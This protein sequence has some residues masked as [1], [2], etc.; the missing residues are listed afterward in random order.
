LRVEEISP[1]AAR[2]E[3][4]TIMPASVVKMLLDAWSAAIG[5]PAFVGHRNAS[6]DVPRLG[7][8]S[9]CGFQL[10]I[11][12]IEEPTGF[13]FELRAVVQTKYGLL[14]TNSARVT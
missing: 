8:G 2:N 12:L 14:V 7:R 10:A 11:D 9:R 5:Q 6:A 13:L 3:L 4:L 1:D